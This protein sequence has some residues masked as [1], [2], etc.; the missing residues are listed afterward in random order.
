MPQPV[1]FGVTILRASCMLTG[2]VP[3]RRRPHC[4]LLQA[5]QQHAAHSP[6]LSLHSPPPHTLIPNTLS[7]PKFFRQSLLSEEFKL[8]Q[9][10]CR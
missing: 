10:T 3:S 5:A 8:R 4:L 9:M 6:L 1:A 7:V 2:K